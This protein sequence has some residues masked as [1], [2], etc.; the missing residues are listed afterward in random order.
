MSPLTIDS[1][2]QI[3][4][5]WSQV[6][7]NT[8]YRIERK[9][10]GVWSDL[11]VTGANVTT[12]TDSGLT[13]G[14][15]YSY[16][17]STGSPAGYSL[18]SSEQTAPTLPAA[19]AMAANGTIATTSAVINWT[20]VAGETGYKVERKEGAAGSWAQI[21]TRGLDVLT[22]TDS[23]LAIN[24]QYYYRVRAYNA[25]GDSSYSGEQGV[26]TRFVSPTLSSAV[27]STT[28][29]IDLVWTNVAG[30]TGYTVQYS[31]CGLNGPV[32]GTNNCQYSYAYNSWSNL[33]T[34]G[35]DQTTYQ[36]VGLTAGYAYQ[37]R[38]VA[39]TTGNSSDPSNSII[40]WTNLPPPVMAPI[41]PASQTALTASWGDIAGETNYTLERKQG[42]EGT[43][44]EVAGAI[45]MAANTITKT[46][47]GLLES[48]SYC[49]RVKAYSTI[50]NGP[51]PAYSN[52]ACL[53]TPLAAPTLNTPTGITGA[54]VDLSWSNVEGNTGYE[55]QRCTFNDLQNPQNAANSSYLSNDSYWTGCTTIATLAA[56]TVSH[57]SSGLTAGYSYRYRVRDSYSGGYSA[58]STGVPVTT[59]PPAPTLNLPTAASTSQLNLSFSNNNGETGFYLEW[60]VRSGADCTT[61]TWSS[62]LALG[63]NQS[64]YSHTGLASGT[65][66]CYRLYAANGAGNSGYSAERSQTTL[67]DAPVLNG[68]SGITTNQIVLTWNNV[69]GNTGYKIE[70]KTGA[71]GSWSTV[72]T[73]AADAATYTNGGLTAGTLY[74]YRVSTNN[75]AGSSPA[76]NEQATTTTPSPP[77][78]T[79]T[80][81]SADRIQLSWPVV[82]GATNYKIERKE[83]TGNYG[84]LTNLAVAYG[85]NYCG[86]PYPTTAC[87]SLT[88]VTTTFQHNGLTENTTYCYLL[89][90]W[91]STGGDSAISTEK[92]TTTLPL[93][94]QALTATP[95]NAFKIQLSW[96]PRACTP[97]PCDPPDGYELERMVRDG[98]WV[99]I[100]TLGADV[101]TFT[102]RIAIDPIKQYRYRVRS[103][104]RALKSPYSEAVTYTPPY[105]PGDNVGP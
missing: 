40:A 19:P 67:A 80:T 95:L 41:V 42:T 85:E 73:T 47:S 46:D 4:L 5:N 92:C 55:V 39:N 69:A 98:N 104:T 62:P 1:T 100:A 21:A 30:N 13:P 27:G 96:S 2:T 18:P 35:I 101:A 26:L 78:V 17:V 48:T 32:N 63:Q 45:A 22:Y 84:E 90:A 52:E 82:L 88:P 36:S 11:L 28:T 29:A 51:P 83:G 49:Y 9:V 31:V 8:G 7:G 6:A 14:T 44:A 89:R 34:V 71:S 65:Y 97:N 24:T 72:F 58:W 50:S 33:A 76:S 37:Y 3:T 91:N 81:Q 61:G 54:Q 59:L 102:D 66:Y 56:N 15:L 75:G 43:W 103:F 64:A 23:S 93:A 70:R 86:Y 79:V 53:T 57:Q 99:R 87:A 77:A 25:S 68:L 60:K 12:Y 20:N 74:T 10:A 105:K 38:I 94:D 16:R